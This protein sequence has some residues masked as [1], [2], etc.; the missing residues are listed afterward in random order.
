MATETATIHVA[1]QF[2]DALNTRDTEKLTKMLADDVEFPTPEGKSLRGREAI[3]KLVQAADDVDLKVVL[4]ADEASETP[5]D[6]ALRMQVPVKLL[7]HGS[8]LHG[9][10]ELELHG[11]QVR[12]F[13]IVT[14][15]S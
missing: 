9:T 12:S 3:E 1:H 7:V 4:E 15:G 5:V 2:I 13:E 11:G 6:D 10:A 14:D 8:Q